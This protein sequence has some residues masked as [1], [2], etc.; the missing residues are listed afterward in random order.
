MKQKR[1]KKEAQNMNRFTLSLF[2]LPGLLCG[3]APNEEVAIILKNDEKYSLDDFQIMKKDF[4]Q[5]SEKLIE[6]QSHKI[7]ALLQKNKDEI[8]KELTSVTHGTLE[9]MKREVASIADAQIAFAQN[10]SSLLQQNKEEILRAIAHTP[11]Q[12]ADLGSPLGTA[13]SS[14]DGEISRKTEPK[15]SQPRSQNVDASPVS[16]TCSTPGCFQKWDQTSNGVTFYGN[17]LYWTAYEEGLDFSLTGVEN[18]LGVPPSSFG[19]TFRPDFQ[20]GPGYRAGACY[21]Y[22]QMWDLDFVWTQLN[23]KASHRIDVRGVGNELDPSYWSVWTAPG[24]TGAG[25]NLSE[26]Q[27]YLRYWT[28]ELMTGIILK[29][30]NHFSLKPQFGFVSANLDQTYAVHY[31]AGDGLD[32]VNV[33]IKNR[34]QGNGLRGALAFSW[35]PL[36][37]FGFHSQFGASLVSGQFHISETQQNDLTFSGTLTTGHLGGTYLKVNHTPDAMR[38][39]IDFKVG[40]HFRCPVYNTVCFHFKADWDLLVW[41]NQNQ[42]LRF[43]GPDTIAPPQGFRG[44]FFPQQGDLFLQG[45]DLSMGLEF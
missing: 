26:G 14:S 31:T 41:F 33:D 24:G 43:T 10:T 39:E 42:M 19:Q 40:A 30:H 38:T 4:L 7:A 29:P 21:Q 3:F 45:L 20:W 12:S 23:S 1:G 6:G 5:H 28:V 35:D 16:A 11:N 44:H 15:E 27:W 13:S 18:T 8:F 2:I 25:V 9:E 37:Y 36:A 17:F 32:F 22:K 34:Y